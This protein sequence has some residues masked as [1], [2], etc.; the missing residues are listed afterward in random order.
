MNELDLASLT[1]LMGKARL[2][3]AVRPNRRLVMFAFFG[4][5]TMISDKRGSKG[6]HKWTQYTIWAACKASV[7]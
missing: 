1:C 5:T 2:K 6:Q 7:P 4:E 3:T